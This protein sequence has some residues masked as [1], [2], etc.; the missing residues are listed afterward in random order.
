M[1]V[2]LFNGSPHKNGCT[3]TALSEAAAALEKNGIETEIMHIGSNIM[4][5]CI[6]C[7]KC[8][9]GNPCVFGDD[10][11]NE[12]LGKIGAADGYIFGS[13]VYYASPNGAILSFMDRL[14][15]AGSSE[16]SFKPAACVASARR[17]GTTATLDTMNKYFG[18]SKMITVGSNY[19]N[20]VHGNT[21]EEV[22]RDEEG[23]QTMRVL[24]E[25]MAWILKLIDNGRKNGI[26]PPVTEGKIKTN[27]IR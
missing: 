25:N 12:A 18:I 8:A 15:Y 3:Y 10:C 19:W 27:F 11:V 13:P 23:M 20:I 6:A 14:F 4:H 2:L 26:E 5:G 22:R 17:A 16:L 21:P 7:G 1:K 24:G 9:G